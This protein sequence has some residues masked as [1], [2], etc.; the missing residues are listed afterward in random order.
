[1][2]TVTFLDAHG[3]EVT[4]NEIVVS[5][6]D[7]VR[8]D[9][10]LVVLLHGNNGTV[11]DMS[12]PA[13]HPATNYDWRPA[14]E[15]VVD[16]GWHPYP[17]AGVWST[18]LDKR[19]TVVGWQGGLNAR[20]FST[21]NY[22]QQAPAGLLTTPVLELAA[23]LRTVP[24]DRTL[25]FVAHSRGGLL[26]R[27]FLAD[28]AD[29]VEL[30]ARIVAVITLHSPHQGTEL[31]TRAVDLTA[32]L[33][34]LRLDP[35][36]V[37][38]TQWL[39]E[40]VN[41]PSYQEFRVGS[42][43]LIQLAGREAASPSTIP[44][45]TF[46]GTNS[47]LSRT[48]T[49]VFTPES[50]VPQLVATDPLRVAYHWSTRSAPGP[51]L[52][53]DLPPLAPE[54]INGYGDV[55]VADARSHLP[56]EATH[57]TT[58]LN[59]GEVLWDPDVIEQVASLLGAT[60]PRPPGLVVAVEP[61]RQPL[62]VATRMVVRATD[63]RS[64]APVAGDVMIDGVRVGATNA[65][66]T[67]TLAMRVTRVF[68]PATRDWVVEVDEPTG[69]VQATGY[70]PNRP[71]P[72]DL[73]QPGPPP[74][75]Q[76]AVSPAQAFVGQPVQLLVSAADP[77]TGAPVTA[78]VSVN[79]STVGSTGTPFRYTFTTAGTEVWASAAGYTRTRAPL[80]VRPRGQMKVTLEPT[81][82][83]LNVAT[84]MLVRVTDDLSGAPVAGQVLFDKVPVGA[85][86]APFTATVVF[87]TTRVFDPETRKWVV[88]IH[89]TVGE[90][91][92]DPYP[93]RHLTLH[94]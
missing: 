80:T 25:A 4:S 34:V 53:T 43:F 51:T 92:A 62:G 45:H 60:R 56:Y 40:Q 19:P 59:H 78:T 84:R 66:F 39:L 26:I 10:P 75:L 31:A 85:T 29:D 86:N 47:I 11:A 30:Q 20:G 12:D 2:V 1:V 82:P 55:L 90:V 24:S 50:A 38:L 3:V 27:Q 89:E 13:T 18:G 46:G 35:A 22:G 7:P 71:L 8:T 64:G 65:A 15:P 79:S 41:A 83:P 21:L 94:P 88:D 33:T 76:I 58:A 42:P 57:T 81:R 63:E 68:D 16:R 74:Q 6:A 32:A 67:V 52:F 23:V 61:V 9:L 72:L 69:E 14:L 54:V 49:W 17:N 36:A 87:T 5:H 48:V 70:H 28:H 77:A 37:P 91:R 44:F 93:P 73:Y